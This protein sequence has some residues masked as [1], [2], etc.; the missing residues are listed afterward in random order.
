MA[1]PTPKLEVVYFNMPGR[2]QPIRDALK[3]GKIQYEDKFVSFEEFKEK[4]DEYTFGALPVLLVDGEPLAESNAQLLYVGRLGG[5]VPTSALAEA[6]ALALL[7]FGEDLI[8]TLSATMFKPPEETKK[9]R[10]ALIAKDG[11]LTKQLGYLERYLEKKAGESGYYV[12]DRLT[13]ADLKL[14]ALVGMLTSGHLDHIPTDLINA[15]PR[16]VKNAN[17]VKKALQEVQAN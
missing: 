2:A 4:K 13:V 10:T 8:Y 1:T 16:V 12:D 15:Y 11:R 14:A 17:L 7:G 3:L 9:L 6:K 5:L